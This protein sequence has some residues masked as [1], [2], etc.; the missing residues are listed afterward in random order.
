VTLPL[1]G[2]SSPFSRYCKV[3][4]EVGDTSL[5]L[6]TILRLADCDWHSHMTIMERFPPA[7]TIGLCIG[8]SITITRPARPA[9]RDAGE[10]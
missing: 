3:F 2:K 1:Q 7:D 8:I 6:R 9:P 10:R 5:R 4:R